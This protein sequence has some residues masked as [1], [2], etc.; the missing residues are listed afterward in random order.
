VVVEVKRGCG[1]NAREADQREKND[2]CV[3][4]RLPG[5]S[6]AWQTVYQLSVRRT[7]AKLGSKVFQERCNE[8]HLTCLERAFD[9]VGLRAIP[10]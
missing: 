7:L 9:S 3:A 8:T 5:H 4:S 6:R 10:I 1:L 2:E